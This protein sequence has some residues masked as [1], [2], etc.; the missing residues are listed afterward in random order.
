MGDEK[1]V[2][3]QAAI[4]IQG[5]FVATWRKIAASAADAWILLGFWE[6]TAQGFASQQRIQ[7]VDWCS[8]ESQY[9]Y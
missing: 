4:R 1:E 2:G 3:G 8:R 6:P 9:V 5:A 7:M